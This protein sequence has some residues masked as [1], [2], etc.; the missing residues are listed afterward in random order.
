MLIVVCISVGE[1]GK[2]EFIYGG[3]SEKYTSSSFSK[4]GELFC[5]CFVKA[6]CRKDEDYLEQ[7][8]EEQHAVFCTLCNAEA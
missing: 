6:D 2:E 8:S 1:P 5:G 4:V 3:K 7:Q